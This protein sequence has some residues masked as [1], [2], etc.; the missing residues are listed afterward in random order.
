[1]FNQD[2]VA[3]GNRVG[4]QRRGRRGHPRG[5]S[6]GPGVGPVVD[7]GLGSLW[8][9]AVE[10]LG[11]EQGLLLW[12]QPTVL[13]LPP[14]FG[15]PSPAQDKNLESRPDDSAR[16]AGFSVFSWAACRVSFSDI[17]QGAGLLPAWR[18]SVNLT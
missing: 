15:S 3:Q 4:M 11:R 7:V 9:G 8:A 2:W 16:V 17:K 10:R 12:A 6:G 5:S 1:M 14:S 18:S 13:K